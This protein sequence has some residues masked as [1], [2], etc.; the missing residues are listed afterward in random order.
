[1]CRSVNADVLRDVW[2]WVNSFDAIPLNLQSVEAGFLGRGD[3][4]SLSVENAPVKTT[5]FISGNFIAQL[6]FALRL[7]TS[8][9]CSAKRIE[10]MEALE[11]LALQLQSRLPVLHEPMRAVAVEKSTPAVLESRNDD[12]SEIFRIRFVLTYQVLSA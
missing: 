9:S 1:M 11:C 7:K 3:C 10:A 12:G 5:Q 8:S 6:Q 2:E 4:L